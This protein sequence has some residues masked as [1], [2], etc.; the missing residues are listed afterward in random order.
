LKKRNLIYGRNFVA[1]KSEKGE[2]QAIHSYFQYM[3]LVT[4]INY[5]HFGVDKGIGKQVV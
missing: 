1:W 2:Y 3:V 4:S 5:I